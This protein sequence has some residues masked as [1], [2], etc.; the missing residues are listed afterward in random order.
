MKNKSVE[1]AQKFI[2]LNKVQELALNYDEVLDLIQILASCVDEMS[3]TQNVTILHYLPLEKYVPSI[4]LK[5]ITISRLGSLL[6][7]ECCPL[8][9][10]LVSLDPMEEIKRVQKWVKLMS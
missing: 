3:V 6:H 8:D 7:V 4:L 9:T 1:E 5:G 2:K 10:N